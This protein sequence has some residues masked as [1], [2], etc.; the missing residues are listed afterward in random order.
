MAEEVVEG[1][2][3]RYSPRSPP[4]RQ[5]SLLCLFF[6][7]HAQ[8][9]DPSLS[10]KRQETAGCHGGKS[11]YDHKPFLKPAL[12]FCWLDLKG[13]GGGVFLKC[14]ESLHHLQLVVLKLEQAPGELIQTWISGLLPKPPPS[15]LN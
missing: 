1:L 12:S 11:I 4:T 6:S 7:R 14:S 3:L 5:A 10:H 2:T 15:I 8:S 13:G 9:Q